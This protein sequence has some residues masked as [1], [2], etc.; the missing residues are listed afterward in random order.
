MLFTGVLRTFENAEV[1]CEALGEG[2][3]LSRIGN[4]NVFLLVQQFVQ[5][6]GIQQRIWFRKTSKVGCTITLIRS[7]LKWEKHKPRL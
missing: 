5:E 3:S 1:F 4:D 6:S 7:R 2:T